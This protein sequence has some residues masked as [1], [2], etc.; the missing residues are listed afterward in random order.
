M[1]SNQQLQKITKTLALISL[2]FVIIISILLI[3]NFIQI[4]SVAPVE[5]ATID[6]LVKKLDKTPEDEE[7]RQQI[8]SVDF[9][10]RKAFFTTLWQLHTGGFML[11]A[12]VIIFLISYK[13]NTSLQ[14]QNPQISNEENKL[15]YWK[16]KSIERTWIASG[17]SVLVISALILLLLS[18][19]NYA[20]F[21]IMAKIAASAD[22]VSANPATASNSVGNASNITQ[23][24]QINSTSGNANTPVNANL[25][26]NQLQDSS[27]QQLNTNN[28]VK[29]V[30]AT[31]TEFP[32]EKTMKENYPGFRGAFGLGISYHSN[33]P[34]DWDGASGK[35]IK[36][37]TSIN[38]PGLNSPIIWENF[39]FCAGANTQI[40]EVYCIN[41]TTGAIL[42]TKKVD[43]IQGSSTIAP[44]VTDDTGY[45]APTMTTDGKRVFAIFANGDV[46][47]F[48]FNGERIWAKNLGVPDN[49]YGHSSSLITWKNLLYI[50]NDNNKTRNLLALST[51]SGDVVW[52]TTRPGRISWAS[53]IMVSNNGNMELILNNDPYMAAYDA[54]SGK[55]IWKYEC[56]TGEIGASPA[57][58]NGI[59]FATNAYAKLSAVKDENPPKQLWENSDYLPDASSPVAW[60]DLLFV[61]TSSGE[62]ACHDVKDGTVLWIQEFDIGFYASP[63]IADGKLYVID[64]QGTM[65]IMKADKTYKLVGQPKIGEK[66]DC[67]P[68]FANG[69]IFIR[70]KKNLYCIG[71]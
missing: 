54:L 40:R 70:T 15:D 48:D 20:D 29:N 34:T 2:A 69:Q 7:L 4:K 57:Y 33:I 39:I 46:I 59:A 67:T 14:S 10:A 44:K 26:G 1:I 52:N 16:L 50:Q 62:V 19:K 51:T 47:C 61:A 60:K 41:R 6:K 5:T 64:R 49:H 11:L 68:A 36:W 31:E 8:R 66:T 30:Q 35:K 17:V 32:A 25:T 58:A 28:S 18:N 37:K 23:S 71:N 55:E 13:I 42:W 12:G 45:S 63:V 3:I 9:M 22:S 65:H 24:N 53:P 56:L 21:K 43:N 27:K 38:L